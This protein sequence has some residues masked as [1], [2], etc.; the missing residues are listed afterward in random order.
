MAHRHSHNGSSRHRDDLTGEHRWGDAGQLALA[1]MF[2]AVWITDSF[3]LNYTTFLNQYIPLYIRTPLGIIF[4]FVSGYLARAGL[5]T[6][7]RDEEKEPGVI[8]EGVFG[9]MRHPIYLGEVLLYIGF[10]FLS[11]SLAAA[12]VWLVATGFL[13]YISRFEEKL[14]LKR[15]GKAY[16]EYMNDVPMWIPRLRKR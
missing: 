1:L 16:K 4:L 13:F 15:F 14:L 3:I 11:L 6:V 9:I 2:I 7:F 10:L 5:K 8:R 12:V